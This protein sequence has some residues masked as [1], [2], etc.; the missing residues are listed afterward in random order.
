M[1]NTAINNCIIYGKNKDIE[2]LYN[3]L[4]QIDYEFINSYV[5]DILFEY[6]KKDADVEIQH[7]DSFESKWTEPHDLLCELTQ[8]FD[9]EIEGTT[10]ESGVRYM[11]VWR[12]KNG[13][14]IS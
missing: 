14:E 10:I 3:Y 9:I 13:V 7:M 11:S 4:Q 1:A 5:F 8:K 6:D 12:Y 2:K